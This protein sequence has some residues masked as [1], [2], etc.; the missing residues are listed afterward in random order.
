MAPIGNGKLKTLAPGA[1]P[2]KLYDSTEVLKWHECK[3]IQ[4]S[5]TYNRQPSLKHHT[6]LLSILQIFIHPCPS[7][8]PPHPPSSPCHIVTH[9]TLV[10]QVH[11]VAVDYYNGTYNNVCT[12]VRTSMYGREESTSAA[13][14]QSVYIMY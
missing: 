12:Q 1:S 11:S 3:H 13:R 14:I 9:T 6:L 5:L 2:V 7:P 4:P 8:T 10:T